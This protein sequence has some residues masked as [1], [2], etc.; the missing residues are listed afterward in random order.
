[1]TAAIIVSADK[2]IIE[3]ARECGSIELLGI[4][5]PKT[6]TTILG[7]SVLGDDYLWL[8][9]KQKHHDLKAI[10]AVD[11]PGLKARLAT[12]YGI[13][14]L[15]TLISAEAYVSPTASIGDG[16]LVQR[17]AKIMTEA[18]I[19]KACK[20]N[21]NAVIHHDARVGD[22]CTMAPGSQLLGS[23]KVE[24]RVFVGAGAIVLPKIR[25]GADSIIGAGAVVLSDVVAGTT[26]VGVPARPLTIKGARNNV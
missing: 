18:N 1:M 21:I 8:E 16:C 10:L 13:S 11:P 26:V 12:H 5:D 7:L 24:D 9:L 17:G 23:V 15:A 14:H 19:G 25:I 20:L 2:E 3:L 4:L 6:L 22:Y